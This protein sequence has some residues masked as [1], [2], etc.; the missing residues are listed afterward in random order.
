MKGAER[1]QQATVVVIG[2]GATGLGILRDLSMRGVKAVLL[3]QRDL[4]YGTSSRFHGLLHSGGRYAVKD[5]DS[6]REC[7]KENYILR[8]IAKHCVEETE[9]LFVQL[10]EDDAHFAQTWVTACPQL[11]IPIIEI[12]TQEARRLEPQLTSRITAAYRIP[13]SAIDGF[14]LVWQNA[15]SAARY[16]GQICTYTEVTGIKHV[17]NQV[18]GVE[19]RNTLT[20]QKD[21]IACDYI[22]NAAG[23][24]VGGIAAMAGIQVNVKPDR[25][26]L[27]A[28]N[29][30]FVSRIVNRLRPPSDGDIFVPHGSITVFGTTS[31]K[32]EKPDDTIPRTEEVL[33]LL[34]T[35][36]VMI[37]GLDQYR[38]LR[39]FTGTRPLYSAQPDAEGRAASRSYALLDHQKDGLTGML[40]IAGG[41]LTTYRLMAEKTVDVVCNRIGVTANC[42]TAE[43]PLLEAASRELNAKARRYFP[44][45]GKERAVSRLGSKLSTVLERIEKNPA[46]KQL[47]C[48]CELVTL[49][50]VEEISS[51][52]SSFSLDDVRR[53]TRLG[54]G[55]CQGA[56]C[57]F[58]GVG[59]IVA[60]NLERGKQTADLLKEFM[61]SRWTGIRPVLW[62]NQLREAEM[63]RGIYDATFNIDGAMNDDG[64]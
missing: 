33:R 44:A 13:D 30:R 1:M 15:A 3:E 45:Y 11:G 12:S 46:K 62:G 20:G 50:E 27:I 9:G 7:I 59:A 56:F 5:P 34:E 42:R 23:S 63:M 40:S 39:A 38:I 57:A 54:M 36:G 24:W 2:G 18:A 17:N 26:T 6:A 55:T 35:G 14:R 49:A 28:F 4:A 61:Q 47:V 16:G 8:R 64:I 48:E 19:V 10:P 43:E 53:K 60:N 58:R 32:A 25:G 51:D 21:L 52:C 31:S 37:E 22:I 29:H 41:K